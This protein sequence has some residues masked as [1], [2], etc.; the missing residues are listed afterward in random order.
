MQLLSCK[1]K[2]VPASNYALH[3]ILT[4][5]SCVVATLAEQLETLDEAFKLSA[6]QLVAH[7]QLLLQF[8]RALQEVGKLKLIFFLSFSVH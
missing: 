2:H 7:A 5:G 6:R 3:K 1:F 8:H 4:L